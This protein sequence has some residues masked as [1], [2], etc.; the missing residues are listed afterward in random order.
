MSDAQPDT[1]SISESLGTSGDRRLELQRETL[2]ACQ[3]GGGQPEPGG[4]SSTKG[5]RDEER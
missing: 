5:G 1:G 4:G 2:A 3:E